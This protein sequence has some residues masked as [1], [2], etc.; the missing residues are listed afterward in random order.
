MRVIILTLSIFLSLFGWNTATANTSFSGAIVGDAVWTKAAGPYL[1]NYVSIPVGASLTI[2]PG[3]IIKVANN[4]SPFIVD[5]TLTIGSIGGEQVVITSIK[6]D[7]VGGDTNGDGG[8]TAPQVGDWRTITFNPNSTGNFINATIKYGGATVGNSWTGG[9]FHFP[10]IDN[11]GGVLTLTNVVLTKSGHNALEQTSG[12]TTI[13]SSTISD[14]SCGIINY[15]GSLTI[16]NNTFLNLGDYGVT[17]YAATNFTNHGGNSGGRGTYMAYSI[18]GSQTWNKDNLPYVVSSASIPSGSSLTIAPGAIVKAKTDTVPFYVDG[19]LT[20]GAPSVTESVIIT[21]IKDDTVGG[22]T[23]N[24]GGATTPQAGDWMKITMNAG[25]TVSI[26]HASIKYGGATPPNSWTGGYFTYPLIENNGGVLNINHTQFAQSKYYGVLQNSGTTTI[27]NSTLTNIVKYGVTASQ[28]YLSIASTTF[29]T[30]ERGVVLYS[31]TLELGGSTFTN[32]A[33][34]AVSIEGSL[35]SLRNHAGNIGSNGLFISQTIAGAQTFPKDGL[36]YIVDYLAVPQGSSLTILP[37][38][39]VKIPANGSGFIV[40]GTLNIGSSSSSEKTHI[41]S[42]SDDSVGGDT[43]GDATTT[44]PSSGD[45]RSLTFN[46]GSSATI[47]NTVIR[48]GGA[49]PYN[50]WTGGRDWLPAIKNNGG[51]L[52]FD[53][54]ILINNGKYGINQIGGTTTMTNSEVAHTDVYGIVVGNGFF[55]IHNSSIHDNG[56]YGAYNYGPNILNATNNWWGDASGPTHPSNLGG[57]GDKVSNNVNFSGWAGSDPTKGCV[58]DCYSVLFI[59]GFAGSRLYSSSDRL[60]FPDLTG[61][62]ND[63]EDLYMNSSGAS[64]MSDVSAKDGNVVETAFDW[65][66]VYKGLPELLNSLRA[67]HAIADWKIA[68][69]DWRLDYETLLVNGTQ[70][71]DFI[72]YLT[73]TSTPYIL[74]T[75]RTLA[76]KAKNHK[77]IIV[78]HSNGG[79][80]AKSLVKM[81]ED[82]HDPLLN[83]IEQV[84]LVAPPQLGA[85]KSIISML[86]GD[87]NP[88]PGIAMSDGAFRRLVEYIPTMHSFLPSYAY[89]NA[90][91]PFARFDYPSGH[92]DVA[93]KAFQKYGNY[94]MDPLLNQMRSYY[95]LATVTRD[96]LRFFLTGENGART[97]PEDDNLI[98]PNVLSSTLLDQATEVH[99]GLDV[100]QFPS[101]IKVTQVAGWGLE[102]ISGVEYMRGD[103]TC[104]HFGLLICKPIF[105]LD[106]KPILAADGDGTVPSVSA[107]AMDDATK[108]YVD[109]KTYNATK[110]GDTVKVREHSN[111]MGSQPVKNLIELLVKHESIDSVPYTS[112]TKPTGTHYIM[113]EKHSPVDIDAYDAFG[114]HTG[115]TYHMID[116]INTRV[117]EENVP[118]SSYIVM[119][120]STYVIFP[121]GTTTQITFK[122]TGEGTMTF[123]LN[124]YVNDVTVATTTFRDI[125]VTASSSG[126]IIVDTIASSSNLSIDENGDGATDLSLV[127]V[128]DGEVTAP[129]QKLPLTVTA[130][131]KMTIFGS[132]IPSPTVTLS[133][134]QN[135]DTATSSTLGMA[136]C[137]ATA[138]TV[139]PVGSYSITC[140]IGTLTSSKYDFTTFMTGTL[141]IVYKWSGFSQPINDITYN[142][143]QSASVFRGGSTVPVKFQLKNASGTSV[144]SKTLP[145]WLEPQKG[146]SMSAAVDESTY[147]D[148]ATSGTTFKWDAT[149]QQ[150]IY[151]W[152]TKGLAM[153]YWHKIFAKLDDGTVQSVVVGLR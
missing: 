130:D 73:P 53:H 60:W 111:I 80:L 63:V 149:S 28:G 57:T 138:T 68:S 62:D 58:M 86:H 93:S 14:L 136:S 126:V 150:Y 94:D 20:I 51:T 120:S 29:D 56:L 66:D 100:Y 24:D 82:T 50:S 106:R 142:P 95:P 83:N 23:N 152:S 91:G 89:G 90:T 76:A 107:L 33:S 122:G 145:L 1:V 11:K 153:G 118:N 108:V 45:W 39:I 132:A 128:L 40:D 112:V 129:K 54:A 34:Y 144:Q 147:S 65:K 6:D 85:P 115:Y 38:A 127:P 105:A 114:N 71:G 139:S 67:E 99:G 61:T 32:T 46:A 151:N 26:A 77:V 125:P 4:S 110:T 101:S 123:I 146:A 48:Y 35:A 119:G 10:L 43:N 70:T 49:S 15:G 137:T 113:A 55:S 140:T 47:Q 75:L 42:M 79:L 52:A 17:V 27:S 135:G 88:L 104:V 109:L 131:N 21:S 92:G 96:N 121:G 78:T 13:T 12:T 31:G 5:G 102:T 64:I 25:S 117:I 19:T 41:T 22:D 98:S 103:P 7:T 148:P 133:G 134:F 72:S 81:L 84:V 9:Y 74:Q 30:M 2:E 59:P 18:T 87:E 36:A 143:T 3:T 16:G 37:G 97:K 116:G 44:T 141:I 8:V 69:Y 124:E